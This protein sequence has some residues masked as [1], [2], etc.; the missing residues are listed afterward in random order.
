MA[1]RS[2]EGRLGRAVVALSMG[3]LIG[4]EVAVLAA[5]LIYPIGNLWLGLPDTWKVLGPELALAGSAGLYFGVKAVQAAYRHGRRLSR[6]GA[7]ASA[8]ADADDR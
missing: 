7:P 8:P 3:V 2:A 4:G 6:H 1:T 5:A